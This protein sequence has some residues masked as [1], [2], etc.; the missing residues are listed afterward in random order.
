MANSVSQRIKYFADHCYGGLKQLSIQSSIEYSC[1]RNLCSGGSCC[2]GYDY[3]NKLQ[4]SGMS[5]DWLI[6]GIGSM[7]ALNELG[8]EM[9]YDIE[10][11]KQRLYYIPIEK[12]NEMLK[13]LGDNS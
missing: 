11:T 7:Y 10:G 5:I 13:I 9:Q 3:L 8:S 12:R 6:S 4:N 2:P 1:L